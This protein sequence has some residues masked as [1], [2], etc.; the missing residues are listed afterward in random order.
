MSGPGGIQ[1]WDMSPAGRC[2]LPLPTHSGVVLGCSPSTSPCSD[3][4]HLLYCTARLCGHLLYKAMGVGGSERGCRGYQQAGG[5]QSSSIRNCSP[6][7]GKRRAPE[8]DQQSWGRMDKQR[9]GQMVLLDSAQQTRSMQTP[10]NPI[11]SISGESN[12]SILAHYKACVCWRNDE[13]KH[14]RALKPFVVLL[15]L[16]ISSE[17]R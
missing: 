2:S 7:L 1:G 9:D 13:N 17:N 5:W 4:E 11:S 3:G 10:Q 15:I 6:S 14:L 16:S 8:P 12:G